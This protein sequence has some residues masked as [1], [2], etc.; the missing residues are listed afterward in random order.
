MEAKL[1]AVLSKNIYSLQGLDARIAPPSGH[2]CH[3]LMVV[4]YC[5]PGSAQRQAAYA[6]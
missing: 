2:V 5:N 3:S 4:S 1:Q 6:I